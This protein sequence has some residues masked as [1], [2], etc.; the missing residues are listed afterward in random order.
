MDLF[1]MY[2]SGVVGWSLHPG[3]FREGAKR[4]TLEQCAELAESM[5]RITLAKQAEF[6]REQ[7]GE[8]V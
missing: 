5:V 8:Q 4:M 2:F 6:E 3:Y 7:K 1:A